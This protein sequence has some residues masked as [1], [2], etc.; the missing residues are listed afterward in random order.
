M[1][2]NNTSTFITNIYFIARSP[3]HAA[4]HSCVCVC[5]M[6]A[7][8]PQP[9]S[10]LLLPGAPPPHKPHDWQIVRHDFRVSTAA[11]HC[12]T[13]LHCTCTKLA[14]VHPHENVCARE[15]ARDQ[16]TFVAA[17]MCAYAHWSASAPSETSITHATAD[18]GWVCMYV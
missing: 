10:L 15:R 16:H 2:P 11:S 17:K 18:R 6:P 7:S 4:A 12:C 9:S 3:P 13:A 14:C 5:T 1:I 8:Q